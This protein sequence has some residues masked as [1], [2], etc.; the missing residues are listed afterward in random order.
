M[1]GIAQALRDP[2][3]LPPNRL[4][5][6]YRSGI[7]LDA[8]RG[9]TGGDEAPED[10][11]GSATRA[12][13]PV[14][15]LPSRLGLSE[16][17]VG[18]RRTT[19]EALLRL[20]PE[21]VA[22]QALVRAAG[23]T[24][25]VLVKLLDAGQRLPVHCHPSRP[26]AADLLG[27]RFGKTEAWLILAT[28]EERRPRVWAGVR[29]Q[30]PRDEFRGWIERQDSDALL[31]ALIEEPV[32]AGDV[33]FVPGGVPH[34]IGEGVFLLEVQE[35]TD[36]S[37]V[38]ETRGFPIDD[39]DAS[40]GLG[41]QRAIEFFDLRPTGTMRR[42]PSAE[43]AGVG[44]LF[45]PEVDPFFRAIRMRVERE[46]EPP[47]E[48]AYAVGV[49]LA[50]SGVVRGASTELELGRGVTFALPAAAVQAARVAGDGL[51]IVWCLGPDPRALR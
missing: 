28:D 9:T 33:F 3:A 40:L 20:A 8:F 39:S 47:F 27:S 49:V 50:G 42:Q 41:W 37:V 18:G 1:S 16:V 4:P 44:S 12:W 10:W 34:A 51:D 25:G 30:V 7:L 14:D 22:G 19:L 21:A 26:R 48:P 17:E 31:G 36:F 43:S 35:P 5:R 15:A 32:S 11:V 29:E 6:F 23:P 45:G 24:L 46:A 2:I 13:T 38:A